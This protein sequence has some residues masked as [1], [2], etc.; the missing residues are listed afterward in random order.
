MPA[1]RFAFPP[2]ANVEGVKLQRLSELEPPKPS[3]HTLFTAIK[4]A[5]RKLY[6]RLFSATHRRGRFSGAFEPNSLPIAGVE[7]TIT[8]IFDLSALEAPE[9]HPRERIA[10]WQSSFERAIRWT[11]HWICAARTT[12][13]S[14]IHK[15]GIAPERVS[16]IPL[17]SRWQTP[18]V[19][20]T[21]RAAR[22]LMGLPEQYLVYLGTIEPRK[23]L[24]RLL[25]AYA[26][27]DPLWRKHTP[28]V[29]A[30]RPVG[31]GISSGRRSAGIRWPN[32]SG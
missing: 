23:N 21:P 2:L 31:V 14:L 1:K 8:T 28:L 19:D 22:K 16:V 26:L 18:P 24:V 15:L 17:A 30:G 27:Q 11:S 9:H 10:L 7:P 12:A 5:A 25:D 4:P 13:D 20:W 29:L 6:A 32:T 3:Q